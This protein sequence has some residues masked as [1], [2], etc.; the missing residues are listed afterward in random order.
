MGYTPQEVDAM[1]LWQF[2]AAYV[3]WAEANG[4]KVEDEISEDEWKAAEAAFDEAPD[5]IR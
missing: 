1:S 2:H 4:A 5:S 3:G